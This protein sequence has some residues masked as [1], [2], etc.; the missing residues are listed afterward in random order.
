[1]RRHLLIAVMFGAISGAQAAD[2]PD[3]LR[4]SIPPTLSTSSVNWQGYYIGGQGGYG[5][6]DENFTGSKMFTDPLFRAMYAPNSSLLAADPIIGGSVPLSPLV[7]GKATARTS[8]YGAFAGYNSQWDD[9]V[10]GI[11]ASYL[12]G[13]FGGSSTVIQTNPRL[14]S[15]STAAISISDMATF[16]ARAAYVYGCFLPFMFGGFAVGN[17]DVSRTASFVDM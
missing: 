15:I 5:S 11:E 3:N 10:I 17:A 9:V 6:A 8:G 1:M 12:H 2:M 7:F 4:G 13:D 14:P 16:R